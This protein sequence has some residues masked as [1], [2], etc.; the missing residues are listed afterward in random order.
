[1]NK[2]EF[3]AS[4]PQIQSAISTGNDGMRIKLDIPESDI[5]EALKLIMLKNKA[6]KV[7]VEYE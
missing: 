5:V 2:I 1:M 4:F 7:T 6:F 3:N